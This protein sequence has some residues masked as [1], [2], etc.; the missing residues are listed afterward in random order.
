MTAVVRVMALTVELKVPFVAMGAPQPCRRPLASPG[1]R[2][3][4]Y[5]FVAVQL[6]AGGPVGAVMWRQVA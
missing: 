2:S 4:G 1:G 3:G 5:S 6:L